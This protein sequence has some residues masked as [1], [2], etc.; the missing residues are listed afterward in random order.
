MTNES[1]VKKWMEDNLVPVNGRRTR[2]LLEMLREAEQRGA[3]AEAAR[4]AERQR[5]REQVIGHPLFP[6]GK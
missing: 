3:E 4:C 6:P 5:A 2:T 1:R